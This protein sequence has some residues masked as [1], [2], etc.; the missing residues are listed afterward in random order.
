MPK[1]KQLNFSF[2]TIQ[3]YMYF[4]KCKKVSDF[5]QINIIP[6]EG[7]HM[8]SGQSEDFKSE[9]LKS[10]FVNHNAHLSKFLKERKSE[11]K[12]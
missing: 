9:F 8:F 12:N 10:G 1:L 4:P 6:F 3:K 5:I 2:K 11:E 7:G